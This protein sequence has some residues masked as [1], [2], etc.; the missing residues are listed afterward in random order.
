MAAPHAHPD[1]LCRVGQE[2]REKGL[3]INRILYVLLVVLA[4]PLLT[5]GVA[6]QLRNKLESDWRRLLQQY[7][8]S[9]RQ[10]VRGEELLDEDVPAQQGKPLSTEQ[11]DAARLCNICRSAEVAAKLPVCKTYRRVVLM[12]ERSALIAAL[13]GLVAVLAPVFGRAGPLREIAGCCCLRLFKPLLYATVFALFV[14]ILL[15]GA[16]LLAALYFLQV[17]ILGWVYL[18]VAI[19]MFGIAV[20]VGLAAIFYWLAGRSVRSGSGRKS[21]CSGSH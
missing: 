20:V 5:G 10:H 2:I 14:L 21:G 4:I 16:L 1:Q 7:P 9:P 17:E 13:I 19:L 8:N 11:I 6:W 3:R 15:H 18:Q 12:L